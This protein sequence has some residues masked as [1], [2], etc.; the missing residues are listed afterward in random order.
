[1]NSLADDAPLTLGCIL[2]VS[3]RWT[4]LSVLSPRTFPNSEKVD[5]YARPVAATLRDY[6]PNGSLEI[7]STFIGCRLAH[8]VWSVDGC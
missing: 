6:R 5:P 8:S 2:M 7:E 4:W 3:T 1:M